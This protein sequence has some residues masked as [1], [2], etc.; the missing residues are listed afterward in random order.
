MPCRSCA[1]AANID[2]SVTE[3]RCRI[4]TLTLVNLR[5]R[6]IGGVCTTNST[7]GPGRARVAVLTSLPNGFSMHK[8]T[9]IIAFALFAG[10]PALTY[11]LSSRGNDSQTI[12][13]STLLEPSLTRLVIAS[14]LSHPVVTRSEFHSIQPGMSYSEVMRIIGV[15]GEEMVH[16]HIDGVPGI[17][18]SVD[19]RMYQWINANGSNMNAM[20]Q[21]DR[22][23]QKAQF[24]L[25]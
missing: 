10:L 1:D 19:T 2:Y 17:M 25:K 21:N 11:V 5:Q 4:I 23:I 22:M 18:E 12:R 16:N 24:G 7:L 3:L 14:A 8:A 15:C 13:T 6:G 9:L 20:F